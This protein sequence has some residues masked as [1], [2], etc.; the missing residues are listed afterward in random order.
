MK[1]VG[2]DYSI[3]SPSICLYDSELGGKMFYEKC[4]FH[5][6]TGVK[7]T[8]DYVT[9]IKN[10][11]YIVYKEHQKR[12]MG[13]PRHCQLASW[14][15]DIIEE[16]NPDAIFIEGY[17]MAAKGM[18]FD[19]GENTGALKVELYK[20]DYD[21][22]VVAPSSIKKFA[23]G[24]GNASKTNMFENFK[25]ETRF[26]LPTILQ[27]KNPES[28]PCSDIVDSYFVCKYGESL[29]HVNS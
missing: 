27:V 3:T 29:L 18:T 22:N 9:Q 5:F 28:S 15:I 1:I 6:R 13:T 17:A 2:I 23:T 26:N 7:K 8:F 12:L 4:I 19:I 21:I 10:K 20:K 25:K 11:Q 16:F 24:K 14:S